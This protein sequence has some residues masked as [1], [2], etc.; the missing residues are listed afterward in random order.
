MTT[1]DYAEAYEDDSDNVRA[2]QP[3]TALESSAG[4]GIGDSSHPAQDAQEPVDYRARYDALKLSVFELS[5]TIAN[6]DD[7]IVF[8]RFDLD[9]ATAQRDQAWAVIARM[10]LDVEP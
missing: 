10:T 7:T 4:Q 1:R 8:L 3:R 2:W 5:A 6:R 9:E